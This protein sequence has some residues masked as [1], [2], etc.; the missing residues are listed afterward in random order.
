MF[1]ADDL[2][3]SSGRAGPEERRNRDNCCTLSEPGFHKPSREN[4]P[5]AMQTSLT[6]SQQAPR[7]MGVHC[8]RTVRAR[9]L[10]ACEV[11]EGANHL[12]EPQ[13]GA[14]EGFRGCTNRSSRQGTAASNPDQ[15][16][17]EMPIPPPA[18]RTDRKTR[19]LR[20]PA[21]FRQ[22]LGSGTVWTV[23]ISRPRAH[24]SPLQSTDYL[25]C[26]HTMSMTRARRPLKAL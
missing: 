9:G 23:H 12:G 17:H 5:A 20:S 10:R 7:P 16:P 21:K 13:S 3:A 18:I 19:N 4:V 15:A 22:Q 1:E 11:I 24:V 25:A 2:R 26:S 8:L 6:L 14:W